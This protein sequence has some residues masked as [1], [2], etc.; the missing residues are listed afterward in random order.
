MSDDNIRFDLVVDPRSPYD[1]WFDRLTLVAAVLAVL[2]LL[3]LPLYLIS[4]YA[5][6]VGTR[7][8]EAAEATVGFAVI[9]RVTLRRLLRTGARGVFR[10][11]IGTF[12]RTTSRALTRRVIRMAIRPVMAVFF[13]TMLRPKQRPTLAQLNQYEDKSVQAMMLTSQPNWLGLLLGV[14]A[15]FLSM[16]VILETIPTSLRID[17]CGPLSPIVVAVIGSLPLPLYAA[18]AGLTSR[19]LGIRM[20]IQTQLD[21]MLLQGYFTGAG[22]FLPLSTDIEYHG[23]KASQAIV[24]FAA[25]GSTFILALVFYA[26][27][28]L[29]VD[30][31]VVAILRM[32]FTMLFVYAFVFS[33]PIHPLDG[34]YLWKVSIWLWLI[35]WGPILAGFAILIPLEI[36]VIL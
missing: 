5:E 10:T 6:E 29:V 7:T 36:N 35:V 32:A 9:M 2:L 15:L 34:Y 14:I 33:F 18:V 20:T 26:A 3:F 8:K 30:P 31:Y 11:S 19:A 28:L 27:S 21:G 12:T 25:L 4:N 16:W 13:K 24:A 17:I 22:S 23:P 1:R